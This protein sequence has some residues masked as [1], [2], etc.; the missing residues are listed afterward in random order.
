MGKW[1][2]KVEGRRKK[3]EERRRDWDLIVVIIVLMQ[4]ETIVLFWELPGKGKKE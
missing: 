1:K 3:R 4:W 2:F